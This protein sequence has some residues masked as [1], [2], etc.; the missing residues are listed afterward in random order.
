[1]KG[2]KCLNPD[3]N[4]EA[5]CRGLCRNCYT[6]AARLIREGITSW[7]VLVASHKALEKAKKNRPSRR[8]AWLLQDLVPVGAGG[9]MPDDVAEEG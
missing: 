4:C 6:L 7:P 8:R 2:K 1:M 9:I 5:W 3:C